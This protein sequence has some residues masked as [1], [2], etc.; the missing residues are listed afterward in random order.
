MSARSSCALTLLAMLVFGCDKTPP[1]PKGEVHVPKDASTAP[2]VAAKASASSASSSASAAATSAAHPALADAGRPSLGRCVRAV[3]P[4]ALG[5]SGPVALDDAGAF[6]NVVRNRA[7]APDVIKVPKGKGDKP[8]PAVLA[9]LSQSACAVGGKY[10]YC[11]DRLGIIRAYDENVPAPFV[12]AAV[13][14]PGYRIAASRLGPGHS[15]VAY[16]AEANTS[17]GKM[18]QAFGVLDHGQPVRL[19]DDGA[20]ATVLAVGPRGDGAVLVSF[21]AR[22]AMMP[23]HA[24]AVQLQGDA[25]KLAPDV[26][27]SI[28]GPP[29][30]GF[31]ATLGTN[32]RGDAF[33]LCPLPKDTLSFGL[34]AVNLA[35]LKT[36]VEPTWSM[37]PNGLDPAPIAASQGGG[38]IYVARVR[39]S[40]PTPKSPLVLELGLLDAAGTFVSLALVDA[41]HEAWDLSL[42]PDA[43]GVWLAFSDNSAT[44]LEHFTCK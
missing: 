12:L 28:F 30:R 20:G 32:A 16:L 7:G 11:Q 18:L 42:L 41:K 22:A 29:E 6:V 3:A 10:T 17:E 35:Q 34:A 9:E 26:V 39:P 1:A 25:L 36:D 27:L 8:T 4:L 37:Y 43:D 33:G 23:M 24:R 31:G 40:A 38:Q 5:R 13:A 14:A 44:T 15:L 19:S 2:K 21:D